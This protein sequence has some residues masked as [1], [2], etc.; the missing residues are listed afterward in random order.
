M[1]SV[2]ARQ[3]RKPKFWI[4]FVLIS[5]FV[6]AVAFYWI[7]QPTRAEKLEIWLSADFQLKKEVTDSILKSVEP[8]GIKKCIAESYNPQDTYFAQAFS[9]KANSV[10]IYIMTKDL[11]EP[12]YQTKLFKPLDLQF[13]NV[14]YLV[15]DGQNY[16]IQFVGDYYIFVNSA[17]KRS[18][19]LLHTAI[20]TL[21]SGANQ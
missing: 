4:A 15:F 13:D 11:A 3:L 21:L 9:L 12:I 6:W 20:K 18:G 2:A 5:V 10:D 17:T 8:Y 1:N 14:T 19:E 16:G 7:A